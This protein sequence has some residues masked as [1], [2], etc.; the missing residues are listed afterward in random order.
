MKL[1]KMITNSYIEK[2]STPAYVSMGILGLSMLMGIFM[3]AS[4]SGI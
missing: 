2:I 1:N 4:E 3:I